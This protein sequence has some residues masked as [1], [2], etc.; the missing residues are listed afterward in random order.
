[1]KTFRMIG[2]ALF[3]ILMC[4]NF[5]ACNGSDDDPTEEPTTELSKIIIGTW[6]QDGDDDI[7]V[8]KS[9]KTVTWYESEED[10]KN[11]ATGDKDKWEIKGEWVY[12]LDSEG[13]IFFEMRPKE[14]SKD[15]IIWK[16]YLEYYGSDYSDSYGKYRLWTWERYSK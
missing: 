15:I 1:M 9:D 14:I 4:V 13:D 5:A 16:E 2:I 12:F 10:Y 6:V 3:A 11:N 8:I 7:M